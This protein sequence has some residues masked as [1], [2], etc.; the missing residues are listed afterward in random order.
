MINVSVISGD[1]FLLLEKNE[2][3]QKLDEDGVLK[4]IIFFIIFMFIP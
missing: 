1:V 3:K 4:F 2:S